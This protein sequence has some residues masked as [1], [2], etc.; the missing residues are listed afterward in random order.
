MGQNR[1]RVLK[2]LGIKKLEIQSMGLAFLI[3]ETRG[4]LLIKIKTMWRNSTLLKNNKQ[5]NNNKN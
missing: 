5:K 3:K 4:Q 2:P 1:N